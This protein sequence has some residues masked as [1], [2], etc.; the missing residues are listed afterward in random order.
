MPASS[1]QEA[2]QGNVK[3]NFLQGMH[4]TVKIDIVC[5]GKTSRVS[6]PTTHLTASDSNEVLP[7]SEA[8][9][10]IYGNILDHLAGCNWFDS[11]KMEQIVSFIE[12]IM[13]R[14]DGKRA[15]LRGLT[16]CNYGRDISI[17]FDYAK[18]IK[19][20]CCIND[21]FAMKFSLERAFSTNAALL[22]T[23][24]DNIVPVNI[25][26]YMDGLSRAS[27][28]LDDRS[29]AYMSATDSKTAHY[30]RLSELKESSENVS[31]LGDVAHGEIHYQDSSDSYARHDHRN[32][33]DRD[34][35]RYGAREEYID[36]R[37]R[38]APG[39]RRYTMAAGNIPGTSLF[40]TERPPSAMLVCGEDQTPATRQILLLTIANN[41]IPEQRHR[42]F[43]TATKEVMIDTECFLF[44]GTQISLSE[45][46]G[47]TSTAQGYNRIFLTL[48]W[49]LSG[50]VVVSRTN[51][52]TSILFFLT[53]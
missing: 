13:N 24:T 35:H 19:S 37:K 4:G 25:A 42:N 11:H 5:D 40:K 23:V 39:Q 1:S 28:E 15:H 29:V 16:Y 8:I 41:R 30:I 53:R 9:Q 17:M 52:L 45:A 50:K 48:A 36:P 12:A 38:M 2:E 47:K 27:Y 46:W 18:S 14:D 31:V 7:D 43:G 51:C 32:E 33:R 44:F 26:P 6:F 10:V 20:K 21:T 49:V 34:R 22:A 3:N